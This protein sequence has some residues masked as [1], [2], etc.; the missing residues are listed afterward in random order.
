MGS[1]TITLPKKLILLTVVST[2][3]LFCCSSLRHSL[4]WSGAFDLGYFDQAAYLIS[5]GQPPIVSFWGYHFLGG[6]GDWILYP[7]GLL[8]RIVPTVY[9]LFAIQ[10]LSLSLGH[11]TTWLVAQQ[12]GLNVAK[13]WAIV[14]AY[15]LYPLVFNL[16]LFDFHPEV[17]AL[18]LILLAV[19]AARADRLWLFAGCLVVILGCRDA[20]AITVAAM[21]V[22]LWFFEKR[23]RAGAIAIAW[24]IG[25]FIFVTQILIPH[26]RP[27]GVEAV[28]RY[29]FLGDSLPEVMA[30]LFLQP[31]LVLGRVFS[32]ETIGYL[33]LL[34]LPLFWAL[35]PRFL[36]PTIVGLPNLIINILSS[37]PA[38]RDLVHQY[39]LPI[40]P[41][42]LLAGIACLAADR[43]ILLRKPRWI[44]AWSLFGFLCLAK[45]SYFGWKFLDRLDT[46]AA[47]QAAMAQILPQASVLTTHDIVPHLTHRAQIDFTKGDRTLQIDRFDAVLLNL[48][49]PGFGSDRAYAQFVLQQAQKN[50]SF[51]LRSIQNDTQDDVYLFIRNF[52]DQP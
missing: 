28:R 15:G 24:G 35:T 4:F 11:L 46:S 9:W 25:W 19:W 23:Q 49:H 17:I 27:D 30:N 29:A 45:Y 43:P 32:G 18:P 41:F 10:A 8:Y 6:H 38:Q 39:S 37:S 2:I 44:I 3:G 51:Q 12:V 34:L 26:F 31:G 16:N 48:K 5:Q 40:L 1:K 22:W 47:V 20:L 14:L 52:P 7:I 33:A 42:L 36:A 21:G 50:G 13:S